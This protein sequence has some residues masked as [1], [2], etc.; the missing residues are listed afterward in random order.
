[1]SGCQALRFEAVYK[2]KLTIPKDLVTQSSESLVRL[3]VYNQHF[4]V[5]L[6]TKVREQIISGETST[7]WSFLN[8]KPSEKTLGFISTT[9]VM[10]Y[11]KLTGTG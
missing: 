5:G 1:M 11:S 8:T 7:Q 9:T 4:L 10:A 2:G 3:T 6:K